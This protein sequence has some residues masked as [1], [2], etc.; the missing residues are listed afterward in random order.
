ANA[1]VWGGMCNSG[2]MCTSVERVYVLAPV[3]DEFV[4]KVVDKVRT[5]R[6][7]RDDQ[8]YRF[9]V[10]SLANENQLAVVE[11]HAE[12]ALT[13]AAKALT[14]GT[15]AGAGTSSAATVLVD[16][17]H[18]VTCMREETFGPA[19]PIVT[20]G[21]VGAAARLANDSRHGPSAT[22]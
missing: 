3:Y 20:V 4:A 22:A 7:G 5:L 12:G 17:P 2:Q 18:A 19:L 1:A 11:R 16:A 13:N 21:D 8:S 6:Q 10:G 15:T 9:D 14:A